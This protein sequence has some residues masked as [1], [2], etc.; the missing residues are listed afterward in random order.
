MWTYVLI[1][2]MYVCMYMY[3]YICM[4]V[5]VHVCVCVS[6]QDEHFTAAEVNCIQTTFDCLYCCYYTSYY[7]DMQCKVFAK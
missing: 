6:K 2:Y 7:S 1:M 5:C 3:M 4:Y